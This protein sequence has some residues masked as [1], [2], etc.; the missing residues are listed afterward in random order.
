MGLVALTRFF[1]GFGF[2]TKRKRKGSVVTSRR[3]APSAV[4]RE[5]TCEGTG[6]GGRAGLGVGLKCSRT[7]TGDRSGGGEGVHP[8]SPPLYLLC[9][10]RLGGRFRLPALLCGVLFWSIEVGLVGRVVFWGS[11]GM[12]N[13]N[14]SA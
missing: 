7:V 10:S 3:R 6:K 14:P 12:V 9:L 4:C 11:G 5:G 1:L 8:S 13:P 2:R